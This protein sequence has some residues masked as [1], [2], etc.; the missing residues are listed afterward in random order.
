MPPGPISSSG[1]FEIDT[2][3]VNAVGAQVEQYAS[4]DLGGANV[5]NGKL[6]EHAYG[7]LLPSMIQESI[8]QFGGNYTSTYIDLLNQRVLIGKGLQNAADATETNELKLSSVF[9][10]NQSGLLPLPSTY[11][12]PTTPTQI[13]Q[14]N[15]IVN[16]N[17]PLDTT[18]SPSPSAGPSQPDPTPGPAPTP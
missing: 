6:G 3:P 13:P 14:A 4:N 9:H 11:V 16:P 17:P 10:T 12:P 1:I 18:P 8:L 5:F 7:G 15:P 2:S